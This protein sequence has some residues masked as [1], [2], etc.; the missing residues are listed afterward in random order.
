MARQMNTTATHHKTNDY[1]VVTQTGFEKG[2][3]VEEINVINRNTSRPENYSSLDSIEAAIEYCE[4]KQRGTDEHRAKL[5]AE[6][7][8][9]EKA[10]AERAAAATAAKARGPLATERQ[11]DY[12]MSLLAETDGQNFSWFTAGPTEYAEIAKMTRKDAS[13]YITALQGN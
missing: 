10:E 2:K 13:T 3:R 11:V 4:R 8:A 12:I 9:E 1:A 6:R 7:A 5:A